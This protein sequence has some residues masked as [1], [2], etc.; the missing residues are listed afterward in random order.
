M[1]AALTHH[2][3]HDGDALAQ[4]A[5]TSRSGKGKRNKAASMPFW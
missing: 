5:P 1:L 2:L 3:G 4:P